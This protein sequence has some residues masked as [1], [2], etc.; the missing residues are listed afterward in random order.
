M[1]RIGVLLTSDNAIDPELWRY[2]PEGVS[3]HVTRLHDW[4][5]D[6]DCTNSSRVPA[7][8][9]VIGPAIR[10]MELI[11]PDA[12]LFACTS[13]S[14]V[15]GVAG[16]RAL[17]AAMSA[18]GAR[19]PVTTS[20]AVRQAM[21]AMGVRRVAVGTPYD[22]RCSRLLQ[23]YLEECGISVAS[24]G[25]APPGEGSELVDITEEQVVEL[26]REVWRPD[27]DA[28]FLSCTALVTYDLIEPL[29]RELG[30]TVLTSVQASMWA[31]LNAA[32]APMPDNPHPL[33]S[34]QPTALASA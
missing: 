8:P 32:G 9:E 33:F 2:C 31:V 34:R 16:E 12:T 26:A 29:T 11:D 22:E 23:A 28:V 10:S 30:V 19:R 13:G 24:L 6:E 27:V 17:R 18:A 25:W 7:Q 14:F 4:G 15:D 1:T 3:L 5:D 20:G 21:Q